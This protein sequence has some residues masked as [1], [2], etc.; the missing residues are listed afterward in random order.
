MPPHQCGRE[1]RRQA[2]SYLAVAT[3]LAA[4]VLPGHHGPFGRIEEIIRTDPQWPGTPS[5]SPPGRPAHRNGH[6][7]GFGAEIAPGRH[8]HANGVTPAHPG[9]SEG[10]ISEPTRQEKDS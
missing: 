1:A 7:G 4:G 3:P 5:Q 8:D 2:A 10:A 6:G 9:E